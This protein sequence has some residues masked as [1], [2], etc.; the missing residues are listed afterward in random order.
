MRSSIRS[1]RISTRGTPA[2]LRAWAFALCLA[3]PASLAG[4]AQN[5]NIDPGLA[6]HEW[7]T[8][9]TIA[10]EAGQAVRWLPLIG[11]NELP[12]FVEHFRG[13]GFKVGLNGTIRMET[14]VLYFYSTH[15]T[16]VDVDVSFGHGL[17]TEWY[18]HASKVEPTETS[19]DAVLYQRQS[20]GSISW[21]SVS[22]QPSGER[23]FLNESRPSH[24]YAA[25]S[26]EASPL[27]VATK[28]G[29]QR[30]QFLFYRGVSV[31]HAPISAL[32]LANGQ[33]EAVNQSGEAILTLILFERRGDRVG[34]RE[35]KGLRAGAIL[36]PP[37]L[38]G[39]LDSLLPEL[40][41]SLISAGLYP[42]E[43]HAMLKSWQD[44][45]FEE[46]SRMIYIV[47]RSFVDQILPLRIEPQPAKI[48]RVFVGRMELLTPATQ[49]AI[50]AAAVSGDKKSLKKY[51]RFLAPMIEMIVRKN[52]DAATKNDLGHALNEIYNSYVAHNIAP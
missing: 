38:D 27:Q 36:T 23:N 7:G 31:A 5:E 32:V 13:S 43:A 3:L 46:G 10:G 52:P 44:S 12:S 34:Y 22:V 19:N 6:A 47:P 29:T 50:E 20:N 39:S 21:K 18:P 40:E 49:N 17:I 51:G 16:K 42:D 30:E 4:N 9:T 11:P 45:W 14:P 15:D 8:F 2:L 37:T 28:N 1:G 24:Y 33:I 25:R 35:V 48:E 26:V 41:S